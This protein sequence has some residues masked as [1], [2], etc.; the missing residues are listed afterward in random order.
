MK[1]VVIGG[2]GL[3][4]STV[5]TLLGDHGHEAIAASPATGVDT[6]TGDGLADALAGAAAVV[7]VS[8]S[9]SF[10]DAAVLDFFETSTRNLLDAE[11]TAGVRHHVAVSIVGADL[12]P[13]SGYLRAKVAQEKL[14]ESSAIPWSI[15]RS[16]QFIEFIPRIADSATE[17]ETVRLPPVAFQPV[18]AA[19]LAAAVANV[20]AGEPSN[21]RI[22]VA[23]PERFRFDELVQRVL[24]ARNDPRTVVTDPEARYFGARLAD[25]SLVPQGDAELGETHVEDWLERQPAHR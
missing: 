23:G 12:L 10:E 21:G 13:D 16:T 5:V 17:G 3:V 1:I 14:I 18:A 19:D 2:T 22:E 15:V 9:P 4:G 25:G 8:N 6:L 24:A 11:A 20:A 7:D